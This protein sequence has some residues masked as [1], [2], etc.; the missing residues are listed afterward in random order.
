MF[1][2]S[3]GFKI[4][5]PPIN[6]SKQD[7]ALNL[8]SQFLH[9]FSLGQKRMIASYLWMVTLLESD[10]EHYKMKDLNSWMYLRFQTIINLE[11]R[12]YEAY[13]Y[14]G[15][16]LSVV[17][18]DDLGAAEIFD[19]GMKYYLNDL[20]LNQYAGFHYY[21]ELKDYKKASEFYE[22]ILQNNETPEYFKLIVSRLKNTVGD[23]N[24]AL[25]V[26]HAAWKNAREGS[27]IKERFYQ[28]AY[29]LQSDIDLE[30]LNTKNPSEC[31]HLDFDGNP[32]LWDGSKYKA[33]KNWGPQVV[34]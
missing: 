29:Q 19:Q 15:Q 3:R 30:C 22:R 2:N 27:P 26:A 1:I 23:K 17:K 34:K 9:Y 7:S 20:Y 31:N 16:Y 6:I 18:D 13:L 28:L 32:Y 24:S 25:A 11:P 14:G 10:L 4:K 21:F 8:N 33:P 12:F 5:L